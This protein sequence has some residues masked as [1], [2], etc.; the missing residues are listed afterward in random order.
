MCEALYCAAASRQFAWQPQVFL[1]SQ[2]ASRVCV[3]VLKSVMG[4]CTL[5]D[6]HCDGAVGHRSGA[7]LSIVSGMILPLTRTNPLNQFGSSWEGCHTQ[8]NQ[9][10]HHW[11]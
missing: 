4:G 7:T 5:F 1:S 9:R 3:C 2:S 6:L 10:Q 8:T 11:A